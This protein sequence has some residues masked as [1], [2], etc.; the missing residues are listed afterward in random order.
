MAIAYTSVGEGIVVDAIE[1]A[2]SPFI[3][4]GLGAASAKGSIDLANPA[5][6]AR[7]TAVESQPT[8]DK[9]QWVATITCAG[10][11]KTITEAGVFDAAGSGSPPSGGNLI[12]VGD[13]TGIVLAVGDKV[14]LT[15]SLEQ[16]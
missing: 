1:T 2:L 16:T 14:E 9:N 5:T 4:W 3:G 6:E 11:G 7:S 15:I 13:F 10:I 12:V 8:A